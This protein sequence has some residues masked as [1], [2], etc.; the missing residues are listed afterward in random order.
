[1]SK[2][3]F[4]SQASSGRVGAGFGAF[5]TGFGSAQSSPL[6]YIQEP[7]DFSGISDANVVVAFKNLSKKDSTTKAKALEDIQSHVS[8]DVEVEE[9]LLEA[10]VK[11][12]P[13]LSIDNARRVRQLAHTLNGQICSKCGKR[14]AKHLPRI[15][16]SWLAGTYDGDKAAARAAQ[17]ALGSVFPN[18]EKVAGLRKTFHASILEYCRDAVLHESVQTL[19]D[20]RSVSADDAQSTYARVVSTSLSVV[21]ALLGSLPEDEISKQYHVYEEL[22]GE[23]KLWEFA[24]H[25]D[26]GVRRS[27][28]RLVQLTIAKQPTLVEANLKA[29]SAA[30][31]YK[32]LPSDQ[33]ASAVDYIATLDV[34]TSSFPSVWT[35]AYSAKKPAA[36]RLKQ[37]LKQGSGSGSADFWEKSSHLLDKIPDAVIPTGVEEVR[38]LIL[39]ARDGVARK[40]E[41]FITSATWPTYFALFRKVSKQVSEQDR[42]DLRD[43][44]VMPILEQY[45]V[46]SPETSEWTVSGAKAASVVAQAARIPGVADSLEH[47]WPQ[48]ADK[49]VEIAKMSQPQQSKDF[50]KSQKHVATSGERWATLQRELFSQQELASLHKMFVDSNTKIVQACAQLLETREGKP[51]GA[52]A[53]IEELLRTCNTH[54]TSDS[55]FKAAVEQV[56][57]NENIDWAS[58]LS[59]RQ[60]IHALYV[61]STEDFF[62]KAFAAAL[63]QV[64]ERKESDD[65]ACKALLEVFPRTTPAKA[66][67]IAEHDDMLQTFVVKMSQAGPRELESSLFMDLYRLGALAQS[68]IDLTL[69]SLVNSLNVVDDTENVPRTLD[70]FTRTDDST[71]KAVAAS[72]SGEQLLPNLLKLEQHEDHEIAEKAA[73]MSHRLS[74][75][76]ADAPLS[77]KFGIVLQN[78][79]STSRTSLSIDAVHDLTMRLLGPERKVQDLKEMMPS[80]DSWQTSLMAVAGTPRH[81]LAILNPLG[82]AVHLVHDDKSAADKRIQTDAEGLSQP[83]RIAMY[84]SKLLSDT[85]AKA[86]LAELQSDKWVVITLLM[87]T[88]LFAE[89]N[90]SVLGCNAMWNADS[91]SDVEPMVLDF[92]SEANATLKEIWTEITPKLSPGADVSSDYSQLVSALEGLRKESRPTS[93]LRYYSYSAL[94]RLNSN[95]FE[96]HGHNADH[97]KTGEDMLKAERSNK[98]TMATTAC[99]VGLQQPL[100]G[101]QTLTRFCNELVADLTDLDTSQP[102]YE[103][104]ALEKLVLLN[105][106]L[107]TQEEAV[108]TIAKQRLIFLVKRLIPA[109][110]TETTGKLK[111]EICKAMTV[112]LPGMQ[113]M[114]GEHWMQVLSYIISVWFTGDGLGG[115]QGVDDGRVLL[116]HASLKMF[117]TLSR[118][119]K[120]EEA[121]DDLVD[122]MK[123]EGGRMHDALVTL[124]KSENGVS[125]ESHQPLM[126]THELL[127]RT[128]A[129]LSGKA[130][131]DADELYPL[132]YTQS[133]PVQQ[134]A[135]ELL[136]KAIPAAQEEV[137]L[138]AALDN[139][140]A[141]LPDE[142]LSLVLEPPTLDSLVDASFDR[143]MPLQLQG[144]LYSWR[145]L[146]DHFTNSSYRV[147]TDYI[148]QLKDGSYM[149]GLLSF[150]FDFLGHTR[151]KP[152]DASRFEVQEY[153]ADVEPSPERD[154]Q[155]LLSHLYYLALMQTPSL[156]KG[157]YLD[158]RSRQTSLAVESWTAKYISPLI[159]TTSLQS[160]AD[161]SEKSV[162]EDPEYEKMAVK[163]GMRSK[164]VNVSYVVDEQ[165]MA[166]KVVLP[167]AYPLSSA[168]V[169]GVS[170]VAVKEEKWQSWLRNCQGVITFSNGSIIDGLSAWRKNVTGAL[171]GQTECAICYSIIDSQKQLPTKRCPTCKN[172]FHSSCLFKWFKTSNASTCP[173]CRNAFNFN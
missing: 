155:W 96:L 65:Q 36:S 39:A 93:A 133:R 70:F 99:I 76:G 91:S 110:K 16:A 54:L 10:W 77:A 170:R 41:R 173:L 81:S 143:T 105:C 38:D 26:A 27:T 130:V 4:K 128:L 37:F 2:K 31:V 22:F 106:I 80:L 147:K 94:A 152:V 151:G 75:A 113:D 29:A 132:L 129:Q 66:V 137:S 144:Y 126:L 69:S 145:L 149:P 85:D 136:H 72:K 122:A 101:S 45:L 15:A 153:M 83:L 89:D 159:I 108:E 84:V 140:T 28:H 57:T 127:G 60:L 167:D 168:Q 138:N 98:D 88:V 164:E 55:D 5:G 6:S 63:H 124:L 116:A 154:V 20:E 86:H 90:L 12:Y 79:E 17:E 42:I 150:V 148:E 162:K 14:T 117:M 141:Q 32:G 102:T 67:E 33:T 58:W 131:S 172:T 146:F 171:K 163:V 49:L 35:D 135:F 25:S 47:K 18:P 82:G 9:G 61:F 52:A 165:T 121:N 112:L 160:V 123:E 78:L 43:S 30:Y 44:C 64:I 21:T 8:S 46:P 50:E 104:E 125:D 142:L 3:Q 100:A 40:E 23:P 11:L 109:L 103:Q 118:L 68:T 157:Y 166:I 134:A 53:I 1:M 139:K 107:H 95:L 24:N 114:Y 92:V 62:P 111:A 119:S 51:Y 158:I 71:L 97:V 120:A 73:A 156:V 115:E 59:R 13:R 169:L 161:W 19:S 87:T 48:M 7:L 34:L 74:S 56:L